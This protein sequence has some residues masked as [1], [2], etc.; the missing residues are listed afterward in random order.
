[1]H[2]TIRESLIFKLNNYYN[3]LNHAFSLK[4]QTKNMHLLENVL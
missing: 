1:M 3:I 4:N 2:Y